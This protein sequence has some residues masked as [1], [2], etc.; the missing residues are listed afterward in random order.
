MI[1]SFNFNENFIYILIFLFL[2]IIDLFIENIFQI[3]FSYFYIF[4]SYIT[5]IS[6]IIFYFIEKYS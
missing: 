6:L 5:E 2:S 4:L 1:L 3:N